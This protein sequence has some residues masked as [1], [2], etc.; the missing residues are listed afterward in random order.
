MLGMVPRK[1][2]K[3]IRSFI[4]TEA[5]DKKDPTKVVKRIKSIYLFYYRQ[6]QELT[7]K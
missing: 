7:K 2:E 5:K 1:N 4:V 6:V 3:A